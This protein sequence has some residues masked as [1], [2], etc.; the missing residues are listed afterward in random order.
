MVCFDKIVPGAQ[1]VCLGLRQAVENKEA[2]TAEDAARWYSL[3]KKV[4]RAI[5]ER[6]FVVMTA[7]TKGWSFAKDLDFY[8]SGVTFVI[9]FAF[10]LSD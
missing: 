7:Q 10:V 8:Q 9:H 5:N 2:P 6:I 1:E 3:M 4:N